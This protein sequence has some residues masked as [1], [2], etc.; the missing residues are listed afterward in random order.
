M[1]SPNWVQIDRIACGALSFTLVGCGVPDYK[2]WQGGDLGG[3]VT[4]GGRAASTDGGA[5]YS[6]ARSS[7]GS[8]QAGT[9]GTIGVGGS[10][11]SG[12]SSPADTSG[13]IGVGGCA[14]SGG[15]PFTGGSASGGG[16]G[17]DGGEPTLGGMGVGGALTAGTA[18]VG[19]TASG[20]TASSSVEI[21]GGATDAA[22]DGGTNSAG[23]DAG[24]NVAMGGSGA[25][26]IGTYAGG[27]AS[28]GKAATGGTDSTGGTTNGFCT[29]YTDLGSLPALSNI[30]QYVPIAATCYRFTV[31][32][33]M[34]QLQGLGMYSCDTRKGTI[35]GVDC[36][37]GCKSSLP[38]E[39]AT[40]GYWYVAF[41]AG[42][43]SSCR[44]QW[45]WY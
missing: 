35:N 36:T 16:A 18:S 44:A 29:S 19:S 31:S 1:I 5:S 42:K 13:A 4:T 11:P 25:G 34:N 12:G 15:A 30:T 23:A 22:A 39:R 14:S 40:D 20:G 7:E 33:L 9:S 3:T 24:E 8:L 6:N 10:A 38:M 37:L 41:T 28:G 45:W 32:D 21:R 17:T 27:T 2:L 43:S 26:G